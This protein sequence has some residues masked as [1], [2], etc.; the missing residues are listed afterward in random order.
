MPDQFW[1]NLGRGG[2]RSSGVNCEVTTVF[3]KALLVTTLCTSTK[4]QC[5][6]YGWDHNTDP[7]GSSTLNNHCRMPTIH[8]PTNGFILSLSLL[9][10]NIIVGQK[11]KT[12]MTT[13]IF[14]LYV[15]GP[16]QGK[17]SYIPSRRYRRT[18]KPI[19]R[20]WGNGYSPSFTVRSLLRSTFIP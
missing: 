19:F 7:D 1:S 11:D 20:V 18:L 3:F 8:E 10:L 14:V 4:C 12:L 15:R 6:H 2:G 5:K 17:Q 16:T 9:L 13:Q